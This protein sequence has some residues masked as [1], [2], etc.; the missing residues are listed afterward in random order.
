[1]KFDKNKNIILMCYP[2]T[3]ST[4]I[5]YMLKNSLIEHID[6]F[7][8][9]NLGQEI[10]EHPDTKML[11]YVN[12]H[13]GKLY[14]KFAT[15]PERYYEFLRREKLLKNFNHPYLLK[16]FSDFIMRCPDVA[17]RFLKNENNQYI[18]LDRENRLKSAISYLIGI[19]TKKWYIPKNDNSQQIMNYI[20]F[21]NED[22][23]LINGCLQRMVI[24][25]ILKLELQ[26]K[27]I[28]NLKYEDFENDTSGVERLIRDIFNPNGEIKEAVLRKQNNNHEKM[29]V[30][31]DEFKTYFDNFFSSLDCGV[32]A[33]E[34]L[35]EW[36]NPEVNLSKFLL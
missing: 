4:I 30:N 16:F 32:P 24:F 31:F 9:F 2:R 15:K 25:D 13:D 11:N 33:K 22:K 19:K 8:Y 10:I 3:G 36:W 18:F 21:S 1:M 6:L 35:P 26:D 20:Y 12:H 5:Y 17:A 34:F 23:L 29:I 7:E 27:I 14:N 28:L